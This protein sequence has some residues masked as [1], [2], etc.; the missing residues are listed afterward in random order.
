MRF[1]TD[2]AEIHHVIASAGARSISKAKTSFWSFFGKWFSKLFGMVRVLE[3]LSNF[4]SMD[5]CSP[6]TT[7]IFCFENIFLFRPENLLP[8]GRG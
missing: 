3:L 8:F 2:P 1:G 7:K 5:G 6:A 4:K